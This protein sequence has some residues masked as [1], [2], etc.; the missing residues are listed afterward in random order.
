[1]KR[2]IIIVV[3]LLVVGAAAVGSWW[4][5]SRNPDVWSM[6]QGEFEKAVDE[7]GLE[8]EYPTIDEGIPA[9]LD[10]CVAFRWLHPFDDKQGW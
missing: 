3:I 4:Y 9:A 6:V 7:L 10:E 2:V 5:T 1:M 8:P